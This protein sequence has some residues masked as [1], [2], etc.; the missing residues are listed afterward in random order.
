MKSKLIEH[1]GDGIVFAQS[2]KKADVISLKRTA[3]SILREFYNEGQDCDPEAEKKRI[4][5]A[6]ASLIQSDIASLPSC[7]EKYPDSDAIKDHIKSVPESLRAFLQHVTR[8]AETSVKISAI[9]QAII[10]LSR[11]NTVI[12]PLQFGLG[13]LLHRSFPSR[14][15]VDLAFHLGFSSSYTE[16]RKFERNAAHAHG[17]RLPETT[18][19]TVIQYMADNVDHDTATLDGR[20]TFHGMGIIASVTPGVKAARR[21]PRR[22]VSLKDIKA[23]GQIKIH[24][25]RSSSAKVWDIQAVQ[26][27]LGEDVCKHI[28]FAHAIG[29]CDTVSS[30]FSIGKSIPFKKA[31]PLTAPP[32]T[33]SPPSSPPCAAPP[34]SP[35]SACPARASLSS[36]I[37]VWGSP[38]SL[39][40]PNGAA[41]SAITPPSKRQKS[42]ADLIRAPRRYTTHSSVICQNGDVIIVKG[43]KIVSIR[44]EEQGRGVVAGGVVVGEGKG[45]VQPQG[46]PPYPDREAKEPNSSSSCFLDSPDLLTGSPLDMIGGDTQRLLSA[47]ESHTDQF[48]TDHTDVTP[49]P[50]HQKSAVVAGTLPEDVVTDTDCELERGRSYGRED[51]GI[52]ISLDEDNS[53]L[54]VMPLS[55]LTHHRIARSALDLTRDSGHWWTGSTAEGVGS[56]FGSH[57]QLPSIERCYLPFSLKRSSSDFNVRTSGVVHPD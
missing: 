23:I 17:I 42:V 1:Y 6:A 41:A 47:A 20:G 46:G 44:R 55:P 10:Q 48:I 11:P 38:T 36:L 45:V 57:H 4:I 2:H 37:S 39:L 53:V 29:G 18:E 24:F 25:F 35:P 7:K 22:D 14:F 33:A 3:E 50:Y 31:Q 21:V 43:G 9:G 56:L 51:V 52:L 27:V 49:L 16:V 40:T 8:R 34:P 5:K 19:N 12:A 30:L 15:L 54:S 26:S 28:L 13:V 32:A